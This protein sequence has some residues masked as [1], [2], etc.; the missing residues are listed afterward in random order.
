MTKFMAVRTGW[1]DPGIR[2]LDFYYFTALSL[3]FNYRGKR[4]GQIHFDFHMGHGETNQ[5]LSKVISFF[6]FSDQARNY[7]QT[8]IVTQVKGNTR[9]VSPDLD[10]LQRES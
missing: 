9:Q 1:R 10:S 5:V 2:D 3:E 7:T 4:L 8:L 6:W